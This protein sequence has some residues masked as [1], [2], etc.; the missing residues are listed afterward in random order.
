[1]TEYGL[2]FLK[3]DTTKE[4]LQWKEKYWVEAWGE[5]LLKVLLALVIQELVNCSLILKN[6]SIN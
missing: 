6:Q 5:S 3:V 1:M 4:F 2:M